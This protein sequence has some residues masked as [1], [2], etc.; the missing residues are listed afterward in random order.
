MT[1]VLFTSPAQ[2]A[3]PPMMAMTRAKSQLSPRVVV[4]TDGAQRESANLEA[5]TS[6]AWETLYGQTPVQPRR[7]KP[8]CRP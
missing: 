8:P 7:Q 6:T 3:F 1:K 4:A 5:L 2:Y